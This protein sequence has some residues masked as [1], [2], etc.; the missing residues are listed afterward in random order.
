MR[1]AA[2][3]LCVS[4][5]VASAAFGAFI[6]APEDHAHDHAGPGGCCSVCERMLDARGGQSQFDVPAQGEAA[7]F[8]GVCPAV[9]GAAP[10]GVWICFATLTELKIQI[11]S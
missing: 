11:N 2:V 10:A 4:F 3:A 5:A 9:F 8:G 7:E 6:G 1:L